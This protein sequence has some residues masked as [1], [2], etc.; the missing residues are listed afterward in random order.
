MRN[1]RAQIRSAPRSCVISPY[2][3]FSEMN[4]PLPSIPQCIGMKLPPP[5]TVT[6]DKPTLRPPLLRIVTFALANLQ[7]RHYR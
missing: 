2:R 3:R 4:L 1:S 7:P 6:A 5:K